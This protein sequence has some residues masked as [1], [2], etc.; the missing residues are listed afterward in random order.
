MFKKPSILLA[1]AFLLVYLA[2]LGLR[3]FIAPDETRYAEIPREMRASGDWIVPRLNGLLY[4][5]KPVLGYW[6]N[7]VSQ[8]LFG[9][10]RF[11]VRLPSAL[12]AG[13][14]ALSLLLLLGRRKAEEE[15]VTVIACALFLICPLVFGCGTFAVLDGPFSAFFTLAMALFFRGN[16]EESPNKKRRFYAAF[17]VASGLAFLTK[18][19]LG[20]ALPII[21]V[22]PYMLWRRQ[23]AELLRFPWIPLLLAAAVALP[24][25]LAI[26]FRDPDYWRYFIWHEHLQRFFDPAGSEQHPEPFWFFVPVLVGG[27]FPLLFL[28]PA[29]FAGLRRSWK[30][31]LVAF[32]LLWLGMVFV[33]FSTSEGK[34]GTYVLPCFPPLAILVALGAYRYLQA[35]MKRL[36]DVGAKGLGGLLLIALLGVAALQWLPFPAE[37]KIYT[38]IE[39]VRWMLGTVAL[40]VWAVMAFLGAGGAA[41]LRKLVLYAAAPA[42]A[43]VGFSGISPDL[44]CVGNAP[45]PLLA[46]NASR[47]GPDSLLMTSS[48]LV[49]ALNWQYRRTDVL[50]VRGAGELAYGIGRAPNDHRLVPIEDFGDF[51]ATYAGQGRLTL[52]LKE[53]SYAGL[54]PMLPPPLYQDRASGFVFAQF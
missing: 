24:W 19:F 52:F 38:R 16:M 39:T 1:G 28:L 42:V 41:P 32:C 49:G 43:L 18:G 53:A 27:A 12:A 10:T 51:A 5:E 8:E 36:F 20:L 3:P 35:G 33:F 47:V 26:H 44:A 25:A 2:P 22:V 9:E 30:E 21:V 54:E 31:P 17:G 29:A 37:W 11:A 45:L 14:S 23:F 48:H 50:I 4:F 40:L 6:L 34:L 15:G 13:L 7:A 46:R